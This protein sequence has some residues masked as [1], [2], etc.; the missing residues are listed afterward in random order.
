MP[1]IHKAVVSHVIDPP[2]T[3]V[4]S[5]HQHRNLKLLKYVQFKSDDQQLVESAACCCARVMRTKKSW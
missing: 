3:R 5:E 1:L 4:R 2:P